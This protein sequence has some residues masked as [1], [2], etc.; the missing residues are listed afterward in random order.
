MQPRR[1]SSNADA[2][3]RAPLA[4]MLISYRRWRLIV[5]TLAPVSV[6]ARSRCR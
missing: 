6:L 2:L 3:I 4:P 1:C 5:V